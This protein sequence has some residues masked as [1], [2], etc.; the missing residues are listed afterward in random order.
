MY[1]KAEAAF[2]SHRIVIKNW[3]EVVPALDAKNV[4]LIPQLPAGEVRG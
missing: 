2:R 1:N 4:V 3:E